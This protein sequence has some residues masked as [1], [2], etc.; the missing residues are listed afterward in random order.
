VELVKG[1]AAEAGGL[2]LQDD[3][4]RI[5]PLA[6]PDTKWEDTVAYIQA[7]PGQ[8]IPVQVQREGATLTLDLV[9]RAEGGVGKLGFRPQ[10]G[11]FV[12]T[13]RP[14]ALSNLGAGL[15]IGALQ[16]GAMAKEV[17]RGYARLFTFRA[18][19]KEL[20][21]PLTIAKVG[22]EAAQA[23]WMA[24]LGITALISMNLAILNALPIPFLDGGH[25]AMLLFEKA[26]GRD[27]SIAVKERILTSGAIFLAAL[28]VFVVAMDIWRLR[29]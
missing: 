26:R 16:S 24:Y 29:H 1:G 7:R 21:G 4:K 25:M 3:I 2:R 18:N 28:M 15:R 23:G 13:E 12:A 5:G 10:V 11:D 17:F 14:F 6:L 27:L 19:L 8:A 9:P 22:K 20:G